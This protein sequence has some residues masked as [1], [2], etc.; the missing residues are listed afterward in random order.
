MPCIRRPPSVVILLLLMV[1]PCRQAL[2]ETGT[3][4]WSCPILPSEREIEIDPH[5]GAKIVFVTRHPGTD[6]NLYFHERSWLADGSMLV[7]LSDRTG[8][9][10]PFGYLEATGHLVRLGREGDAPLGSLTCS[11]KGNLIYGVQDRTIVA[12]AVRA[13]GDVEPGVNIR[14]RKIAD[15]PKNTGITSALTENSEGRLLAF[16]YQDSGKPGTYGIAAVE[17]ETGKLI[18]VASV[19]FRN[20]HLQF[21]W[22]R[23]DLLLFARAYP[24][25]DRMPTTAPAGDPHYRTWLVDMSGRPPRPIYPQKPGELVTHEC[26]WTEDRITFCG[27][28]H[29]PEESHLKVFDMKTGRVSIIG[30]GSWWPG[31]NPDEIKKRAWWHAAGSPDGRWAVADNFYGDIVLFDG[32]T[33]EERLLTAGHRKLGEQSHPHPGWAPSSDRVVFASTRRGNMDVVIAHVPATWRSGK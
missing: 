30:A 25:G 12:W 16:S 18:H 14:R 11:R 22:S 13:A 28:H 33:T 24:G 10:E 6:C 9:S 7:F 26:W 31:G 2:A 4:H 1:M 20:Y 27:G 32:D 5:S 29:V 8:R 17:I 15:L 21:S 3:D 19:G 23:P